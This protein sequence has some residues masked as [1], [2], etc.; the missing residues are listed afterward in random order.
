MQLKSEIGIATQR[1]DT[2]HVGN[3]TAIKRKKISVLYLQLALAISLSLA[4]IVICKT[5]GTTIRI[6]RVWI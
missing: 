4:S 6:V 5:R 1:H 3:T 2:G